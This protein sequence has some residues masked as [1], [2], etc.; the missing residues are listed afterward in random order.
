MQ[1]SASILRRS[2]A[3]LPGPVPLPSARSFS[4][5]RLPA[6][7]L[8]VGLAGCG[9]HERPAPPV[10]EPVIDGDEIRLPAGSAQGALLASV[11]AR[12]QQSESVRLQGRLG[13]DETRT[14]RVDAPVPGRIVRL[15]AAPGDV[16]KAGQV[17]AQIASPE[18]GQA[19]ADARRAE[20]DYE[21]AA[22]SLARIRELH[23]AGIT[24]TRELQAAEAE[25]E[26]AGAERQ[27]TRARSASYGV[28]SRIDQLFPL[29]APVAGVV[30]ERTAAPGLEVRPDQAQPGE[31]ALFVVSDPT[32]LWARIDVPES[33]VG[34]VRTG[35]SVALKALALPT[36]P[37]QARITHVS[38]FI[39]PVTRTLVARA[40]VDNADRA[41]KAG[42]FVS[43][44]LAVPVREAVVVPSSALFLIGERYHA[45]VDLGDGRYQRREVQAEEAALGMM[46]VFGGL[47]SGERAVTGGGLH[48]QQLL[49]NQR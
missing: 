40:E 43:T 4:A 45:F 34:M 8:A 12:L 23:E 6:L 1:R 21:V 37:V 17:L 19:Q 38:D 16:V 39:D 26:R 32:R 35:Q 13:W 14:A 11:E 10:A 7:L 48:L 2:R 9:S 49:G 27:R 20:V 28:G 33:L 47:R 46:R 15:L 41:L 22:K 5:R 18:I 44:E 3:A 42:M 31:P 24:P 36:R 25:L 29:R 30:V